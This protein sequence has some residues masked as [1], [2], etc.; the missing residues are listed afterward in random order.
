MLSF[1]FLFW[2][3]PAFAEGL[4]EV[5]T[6]IQ[7]NY[8]K[9]KDFTADFQQITIF[10]SLKKKE[11][12]DGVV[13]FKKPGKMRWDYHAPSFQ[14]VISD[15][16]KLW[17][18]LPEEEQVMVKDISHALS[19]T[20]LSFLLGLGNLK[21]DFKITFSPRK[22][23][24]LELVPKQAMGN[25]ERLELSVNEEDYSVK[26]VILH[27]LMGNIIEIKFSNMVQNV[28]PEDS[29]FS[30]SPPEGVEIISSP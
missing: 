2:F 10:K 1:G 4:E 21:K 27:D 25:I 12:T 29:L 15:G 24:W 7:Q 5:V 20:P 22:N 26:A 16:E 11:I 9:I 3:Q 23:L 14:K 8:L 19:Q 6:K 28:G 17:I 30:F 18:Y 13:Y